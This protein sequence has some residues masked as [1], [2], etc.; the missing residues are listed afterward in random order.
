MLYLIKNHHCSI[1][2]VDKDQVTSLYL[3]CLDK[4]GVTVK[5]CCRKI[6]ERLDQ[7]QC[8]ELVKCMEAV[9]D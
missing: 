1:F 3:V 5:V 8:Y 6:D 9:Q 2:A 7:D 4:E